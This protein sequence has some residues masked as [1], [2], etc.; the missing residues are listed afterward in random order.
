M[1]DI[2]CLLNELDNRDRIKK[3]C[4]K[5]KRKKIFILSVVLFFI[6]FIVGILFYMY[7]FNLDFLDSTYNTVLI[8]TGIDV[9]LHPTNSAQKIFIIIY[10]L[11]TIILIVSIIIGAIDAIIDGYIDQDG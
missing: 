6:V 7:L 9:G 8:I 1:D 10:S 5:Q 11:I 4:Q 3:N 2:Q